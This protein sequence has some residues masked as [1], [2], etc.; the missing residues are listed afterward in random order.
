MKKIK[1]LKRSN[2][3]KS[4]VKKNLNRTWLI[5]LTGWYKM[6]KEGNKLNKSWLIRENKKNSSQKYKIKLKLTMQR[7]LNLQ[8]KIMTNSFSNNYNTKIVLKR[9]FMLREQ[10]L[11]H[12]KK[13]KLKMLM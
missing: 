11:Q 8:R 1:K 5:V 12:Y 6:I 10:Q 2:K 9:D 13:S 4:Q 3:R 7:F